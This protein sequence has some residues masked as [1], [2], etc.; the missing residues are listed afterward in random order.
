MTTRLTIGLDLGQSSDPTALII[1][2]SNEPDGI[3]PASYAVRHIERAPLGTRY[4][5]IVTH[6]AATINALTDR[7]PD[8]KI[9]LVVDHTGVGRPVAD[10]LVLAALPCDL[11]LVTITGGNAVTADE[12]SGS[13]RVPKR[14][15]AATV[16]RVL[17]EDRLRIPRSHPMAETLLTELTGFRVTVNARGHDSYAAGDDWRS[18]P[19]DDLVLALALACWWNE[20]HAM[21]KVW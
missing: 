5:A 11:I 21:V 2:A 7:E 8:A 16:Q 6:V 9:T 19:H 13:L 18:A 17:Q 15:L 10:M 12:A 1:V 4:P 3:T 20:Q 14:D